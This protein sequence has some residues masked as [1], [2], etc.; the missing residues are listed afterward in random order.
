MADLERNANYLAAE[1]LR[2]RLHKLRQQHVDEKLGELD[3]VQQEDVKV[4]YQLVSTH[5]KSFDEIWAQKTHE[6]KMRSDDLLAAL[7]VVCSSRI[8]I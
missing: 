8:R 1:K 7:K 2:K 4:F 3:S 5:Q 6:H